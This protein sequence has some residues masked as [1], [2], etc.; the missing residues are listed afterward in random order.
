MR[1][2]AALDRPASV[3]VSRC[4]RAST[5]RVVCWVSEKQAHTL[6]LD[7]GQ[8][9]IGDLGYEAEAILTR[10]HVTVR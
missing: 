1:A 2:N 8:P 4:Q 7:N 9:I 5:V 6:I 10:G 3:A